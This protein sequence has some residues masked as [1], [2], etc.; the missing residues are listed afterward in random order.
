MVRVGHERGSGAQFSCIRLEQPNPTFWPRNGN[1]H[2]EVGGLDFEQPWIKRC[3]YTVKCRG[4]GGSSRSRHLDGRQPCTASCCTHAAGTTR[5][6]KPELWTGHPSPRFRNEPHHATTTRPLSQ[7]PSTLHDGRARH[8]APVG[9]ELLS[10][11][12]A[13]TS[14]GGFAFVSF[15]STPGS[16]SLL[17]ENLGPEE[18]CP[19]V[20]T[21]ATLGKSRLQ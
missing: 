3:T 15:P 17:S 1:H 19:L 18:L 6:S 11:C 16:D 7:D 21:L 20:N 5:V 9:R 13:G 10:R 8:P 14:A 2:K 4:V 12:S